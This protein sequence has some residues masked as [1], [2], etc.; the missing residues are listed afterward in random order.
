MR[1][2]RAK[3]W[4]WTASISLHLIALSVLAVSEFSPKNFTADKEKNIPSARIEQVKRIVESQPSIPVSKFKLTENT[5][6]ITSELPEN[7]DAAVDISKDFS[8]NSSITELNQFPPQIPPGSVEFFS[9]GADARRVCFVADCSGSMKGLFSTVKTELLRSI[10]NLQQDQYFSIIFFGDDKL[11]MFENG[12][13]VRASN[14]AKSQAAKF[15]SSVEPKGKTNAA[16]ALKQLPAVRDSDGQNPSVVFFLSDGFE[17]D[18]KSSAGSFEIALNTLA[19][20]MPDTI[21]NTIG[22]WPIEDD[23]LLLRRIAERT[24]GTFIRFGEK[25]QK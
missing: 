9:A 8:L 15:I 7:I 11:F 12:R 23:C 5:A 17:L 19:A 24:G 2:A 16:Q 20:N 1:I 4:A 25:E 22:F 14:L 3:F 6:S 10:D 18:T 21:I 13:L